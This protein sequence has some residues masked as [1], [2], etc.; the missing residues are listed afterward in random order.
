MV[1]TKK[2]SRNK[3]F[4][5][6]GEKDASALIHRAYKG[7]F[8]MFMLFAALPVIKSICA[9]GFTTLVFATNVVNAAVPPSLGY[10]PSKVNW[11]MITQKEPN[12]MGFVEI[13]KMAGMSGPS[14]AEA[15]VTPD[16]A[17]SFANRM[18]GTIC[19]QKQGHSKVNAA[20]LTKLLNTDPYKMAMYS[21]TYYWDHSTGKYDDILNQRDTPRREFSAK[22][23]ERAKNSAADQARR[24]AETI[25]SAVSFGP[26]IFNLWVDYKVA[27][28]KPKEVVK[29]EGAKMAIE[30]AA[31]ISII[32]VDKAVE[33]AKKD[34][35]KNPGKY[36]EPTEIV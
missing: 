26:K 35:E 15:F 17:G 24:Q 25:N 22:D 16:F 10:N 28:K 13:C 5:K 18:A 20:M 7:V 31:K 1:V 12:A 2:A 9:L 27:G 21:M 30:A 19:V 8:N 11:N 29:G 4:C 23:I 36:V 32:D 14:C 3:K 33:A 34:A 6:R